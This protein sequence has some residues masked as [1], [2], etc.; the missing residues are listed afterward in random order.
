MNDRA[1]RVEDHVVD[2]FDGS[3]G[4]AA[5]IGFVCIQ[6]ERMIDGG[7]CGLAS[8]DLNWLQTRTL[9]TWSKAFNGP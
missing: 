8:L 5:G 3:N 7:F 9:W 6:S 1:A 2:G 4:G